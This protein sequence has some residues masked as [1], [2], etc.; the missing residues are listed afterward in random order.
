MIS[1]PKQENG[2]QPFL[3]RA[4]SFYKQGFLQF[5]R[6]TG[7]EHSELEYEIMMLSLITKI[8]VLL[9]SHLNHITSIIFYDSN[10]KV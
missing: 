3:M 5:I 1:M 8:S 6:E 9:T 7:Y 4:L 10:S 2:P